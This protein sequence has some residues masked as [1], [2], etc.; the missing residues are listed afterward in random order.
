MACP[1]LT[2]EHSILSALSD[3]KHFKE[4]KDNRIA[5][6]G[7]H[8]KAFILLEKIPPFTVENLQGNW[9]ITEVNNEAVTTGM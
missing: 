7:E 4:E 5:L 2:L 8:G 9:N 6:C 1:D 3:V